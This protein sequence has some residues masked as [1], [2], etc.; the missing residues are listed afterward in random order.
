M[1]IPEVTLNTKRSLESIFDFTTA[2]P[3]IPAVLVRHTNGGNS[4]EAVIVTSVPLDERARAYTKSKVIQL[5][6]IG[7]RNE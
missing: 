1:S 2:D 7:L 4:R 5:T 6:S 3:R